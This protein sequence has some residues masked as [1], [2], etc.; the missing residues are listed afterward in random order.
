M[1]DLS[2][3]QLRHFCAVAEYGS[4]TEAAKNTH[5]SATAVGAAITSLER[6]LGTVLCSRER[7][8]GVTLTPSGH[9]FY[10]EA[11]RLVRGA[12][13]LLRPD[14][15]QPDQFAG[16]LH[17]GAFGPTSPAILPELLEVFE[18]EHPEISVDFTT[19]TVLEL[20]EGLLAGDLH[21]AFSY[22]VFSRSGVLPKGL[23]LKPLYRTELKVMI[24]PRHPLAVRDRISIDDLKDVPLI[25]YESNPARRFSLPALGRL[26]PDMKV[27]YMTKEYELMRAMVGRGLGYSL[28]MNPMP[29]GSSYEGKP[30]KSI[31]LDPPLAGTTMVAIVPDGRWQHPAAKTIV[32]LAHRLAAAGGIGASL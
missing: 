1:A 29:A 12:D 30:L 9:H 3:V 20:V 28:S 23:A 26:H 21:C 27:R 22:D 13:D 18:Q 32:G 10:R 15:D 24:S 31:R 19:G 4:I 17:V 11:K 25:V 6:T 14:P 5:V 2:L 16:P 8:R 7:S